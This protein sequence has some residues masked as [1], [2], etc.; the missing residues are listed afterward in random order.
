MNRRSS[1]LR[2]AT[3]CKAKPLCFCRPFRGRGCLTMPAILSNLMPLMTVSVARRQVKES[4]DQHYTQAATPAPAPARAPSPS[5][6]P[7]HPARAPSRSPKPD[8]V[9]DNPICSPDS[10]RPGRAEARLLLAGHLHSDMSWKATLHGRGAHW[11]FP[12]TT[13][14][15]N[16]SLVCHLDFAAKAIGFQW[17]RYNKALLLL[18]ECRFMQMLWQQFVFF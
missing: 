8:G 3:V 17:Y 18:T 9:F 14:H 16:P 1:W 7:E 4:R 2:R 13:C 6:Q 11:V 12:V 5:T 10:T 15:F